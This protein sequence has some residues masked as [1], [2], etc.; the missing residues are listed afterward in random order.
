[1]NV[2]LL[3]PRDEFALPGEP[4]G[5][6]R[7][8][9]L[10]AGDGGMLTPPEAAAQDLE[11][12][13]DL[14]VLI[15]TMAAGDSFVAD[16]ARAVLLDA[17]RG[18]VAT[19]QHRQQTVYDAIANPVTVRALYELTSATCGEQRRFY[20]GSYLRLPSSVLYESRNGLTALLP[21]LRSLREIAARERGRFSSPG[22]TDLFETV[23][24]ELSEDYLQEVARWIRTLS[25]DSGVAM[26]ARLGSHGQGIEYTLRERARS[27]PWVERMLAGSADAFTIR[28]SDRDE[29]GARMVADLEARG[30]NGVADAVAQSREHVVRF[31][32][33]LRSQLAF[34]VGCNHLHAV[35]TTLGVA[36]ARPAVADAGRLVWSAQGVYDVS[37]AIRMQRQVV[38][39]D[40]EADGR[41]VMVIT[42]ANQGGKSTFLRALGLAQLMMQAGMF[43]GADRFAAS[44]T[45]GIL[46]HY[47][48]EEDATL[49][50]GKLDEE[51]LR[52]SRLV[53]VIRPGAL[54]LFNESFS[55]TNDREGSELAR[56]VVEAL[57]ARG[58]RIAFVTHLQAFPGMLSPGI[59]A[60]LLRAERL[61]DGTRTY[62]LRPGPAGTAFAADVYDEVFGGTERS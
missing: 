53:E 37:L 2:R 4:T 43:V 47:R 59:N 22:F 16:A 56:Q 51:L 13:L 62:R 50:S 33:R 14:G 21:A 42:G 44:V 54:L 30:L 25:F 10:T 17:R 48:R 39:N 27:R 55:S 36:A 6:G 24:S 40:F 1:M 35:L 12:D 29:S 11:H 5:A 15:E 46:T 61:E 32:H 60:L 8:V 38:P 52:L 28:L 31:F 26:T 7:A 57:T 45:S 58:V 41:Q 3:H 34:C 18:D 20:I 23:Q 49:V 19:I 9:P